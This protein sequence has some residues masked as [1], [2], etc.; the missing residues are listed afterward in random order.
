M[1]YLRF[2]EIA[3]RHGIERVELEALARE[4]II[5]IKQTLDEEPVVSSEDVEKACIARMLMNELD[6]NLAGAEVIVHMRAEM[7]AMRRQF[8]EILQALVEEIRQ[9][10][11]R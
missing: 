7:I 3:E 10:A 6:V 2:A 9:A 5:E 4:Q 8:G 1:R 11:A